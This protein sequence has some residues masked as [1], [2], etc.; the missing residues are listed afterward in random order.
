MSQDAGFRQLLSDA[1]DT[2][3][4]RM[5]VLVACE[6]AERLGKS[7]GHSAGTWAIDGNTSDD[8]R[9]ALL[10]GIDDGDPAAY[11]SEPSAY[12][13]DGVS[14]IL[15][16]LDLHP[17]GDHDDNR[18]ILER[19]ENAFSEAYWA[20]VERAARVALSTE[21]ENAEGDSETKYGACDTRH[22]E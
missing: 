11:D 3:L 16:D 6:R 18:T 5:F 9:R 12:D 10:K 8:T 1:D 17:D 4:A 22:D 21:T 7:K 15:T 14:G 19:Y 13:D 2:N 20:E